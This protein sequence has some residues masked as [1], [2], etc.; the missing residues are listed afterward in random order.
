[1]RMVVLGIGS[2]FG[3]DRV[4]WEVIGRLREAG[5]AER[6]PAVRFEAV[7]R[8]GAM[9][10]AELEGVDG[11]ILV[12]AVEGG[13]AAGE[14]VRLVGGEI[15][16]RAETLLSSHGLGLGPALQ[17]GR[18]LG[19]LPD[20]LILHGVQLSTLPNPESSGRSVSPPLWEAVDRLTLEIE[21]E[22]QRFS[23]S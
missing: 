10:L 13:L 16:A 17:M 4:G 23:G 3:D 21:E 11:A 20:T 14:V 18:A 19:Q 22:L 8:P 7:D 6:F 9:L 1:M 2:P 5:V 15:E 12:D